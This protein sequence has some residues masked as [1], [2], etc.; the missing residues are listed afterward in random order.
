[1]KIRSNPPMRDFSTPRRAV[2]SSFDSAHVKI[3]CTVCVCRERVN[4]HE[5]NS[6]NSEVIKTFGTKQRNFT[7]FIYQMRLPIF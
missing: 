5:N 4:T 1:M 2:S 3:V 6:N 7:V